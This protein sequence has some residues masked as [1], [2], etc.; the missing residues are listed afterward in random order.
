MIN[1]YWGFMQF[2]EDAQIHIVTGLDG[3]KKYVT[4]FGEWEYF[5]EA[6]DDF[7]DKLTK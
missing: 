6:Q 5:N 2:V 7:L 1:Y 3:K 4:A